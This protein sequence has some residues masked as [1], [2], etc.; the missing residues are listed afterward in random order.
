MD[1]RGTAA[2]GFFDLSL[3]VP[4]FET[5]VFETGVFDVVALDVVAF[6]VVVVASAGLGVVDL[7]AT[8]VPDF[9]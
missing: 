3:E 4:V 8:C 9:L 2:T 7:A 6:D 1:R 5:P